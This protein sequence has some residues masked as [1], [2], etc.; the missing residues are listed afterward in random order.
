MQTRDTHFTQRITGT[1]IS[2]LRD[3]TWGPMRF[4]FRIDNRGGFEVTGTLVS[5]APEDEQYSA[6][7]HLPPRWRLHLITPALNDGRRPVHVQLR[8][9]LLDL[10]DRR[11]PANFTSTAS[12]PPQNSFL[13]GPGTPA[14]IE[15]AG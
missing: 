6:H 9:G 2:D 7:R 12:E 4:E 10:D 11:R 3:T 8:D 5:N 14:E 15:P 13:L 1:W